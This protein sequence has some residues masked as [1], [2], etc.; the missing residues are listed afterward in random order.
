MGA[1]LISGRELNERRGIGQGWPNKF[2]VKHFING[3]GKWKKF[4]T[5]V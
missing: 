3:P 5:K 2:Y 4:F 1:F